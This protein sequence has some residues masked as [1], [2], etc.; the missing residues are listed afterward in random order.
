MLDQFTPNIQFPKSEHEDLDFWDKNKVF[1]KSVLQR[2]PQKQFV[3]YDG[4][5]FATGLPHYGNFLPNILKD[6]IPRYWTMQ[7]YRVER[8]FGWDCHGLPVEYE[9][10]KSLNLEGRKAIEAYGIGNYNE[11][12]RSIVL[13]YTNEWEK[14]IHRI[15]RWVDFKHDYKT[16]DLSYMESVWW[17]FKSCWDQGFIYEGYKVMPYSTACATPLS[18]FE[19]NSNYKMVQDPSITLLFKKGATGSDPDAYFLAWTTTPWT[20]PSNLALAV[21]PKETYVEIEDV[22]SQKHF[23][24]AQKRLLETFP[25]EDSYKIIHTYLGKDLEGQPYE[26][27]FPYFKDHPN[28]F[29]LI[30]ADFVTMEDGTGI[31]HIAPGF[32]EDDYFACKTQGIEVVCPVD[33]DGKFTSDVS[34]YE[35]ILVKEA[36][37]AILQRLKQEGKILKHETLEHSYPFCWRSDTPLIYRAISSWFVNVEKIKEKMIAANQKTNWV[38]EHLKEGRFGHCLKDARD[39]AISTDRYW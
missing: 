32:G 9:I 3:F 21:H 19:A 15:G 6:I 13:K 23:I 34:D 30:T 4:P 18:N 10:D 28:A 31:V 17:V 37:K 36:D 1:E 2:D 11:A 38:P 26:P 7:G 24:L 16:M 22:A 27:L 29:R 25:K 8:R 14:T 33:D 35:G 5:P 12:C 39:W 20:L